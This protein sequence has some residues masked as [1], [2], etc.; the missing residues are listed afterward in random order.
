MTSGSWAPA[1]PC[2]SWAEGPTVAQVEA[3]DTFAHFH[4]GCFVPV[5]V[6]LTLYLFLC[7]VYYVQIIFF[8]IQLF[9][10]ASKK[11]V[12]YVQL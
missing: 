7:A 4:H 12:Y 11:I 8:T 6:D 3:L 1:D 10:G 2:K 9:G 5:R